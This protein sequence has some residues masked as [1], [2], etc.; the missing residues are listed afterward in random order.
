MLRQGAQALSATIISPAGARFEM[1]SA[2]PASSTENQNE[3]I[4]KLIVRLPEKVKDLRLVIM[5]EPEKT[6]GPGPKV[7]PLAQWL[8]VPNAKFQIPSSRRK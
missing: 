4:R 6:E 8:A 2:K 5:M 7:E 1:A 3:G